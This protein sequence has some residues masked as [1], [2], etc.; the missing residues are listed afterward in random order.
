MESQNELP[1]P[2]RNK[3]ARMPNKIHQTVYRS[4]RMIK[5]IETSETSDLEK[6]SEA[7]KKQAKK[8][9]NLLWTWMHCLKGITQKNPVEVRLTANVGIL[10][11]LEF[12]RRKVLFDC[13]TEYKGESPN[14]ELKSGLDLKNQIVGVL[15][16]L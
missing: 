5:W 13:C 8:T 14:N 4:R 12:T 16:K 3:N 6:C 9:S 15:I 11:T 2:F 10:H 7:P 1:L